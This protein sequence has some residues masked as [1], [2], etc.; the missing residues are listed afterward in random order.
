MSISR[1]SKLT[2][3]GPLAQ[4]AQ[5]MAQVQQMGCL[6][7]IPLVEVD[8]PPSRV[9][10][11][12]YRALHFLAEVEGERRQLT[13]DPDFNAETFVQ[14]VLSLRQALRETA[15]RRDLLAHQVDILRPWGDL[16][17][18]AL[19]DLGGAR[20]W[21]YALPVKHRDALDAVD[22]PWVA[23]RETRTTICLVVI[24]ATEPDAK[25]LPVPRIDMPERSRAEIEQEIEDTEVLLETLRAE[26]IAKTRFLKLFRDRISEL[27][28]RAEFD[29]AMTQTRDDAE[30]FTVQGWVPQDALPDL[31]AYCEAQGVA[32]LIET[33][34]WDETPP[35]LL[36]QPPAEAAGVDLAMF[37]QVPDY[38]AWD[39]TRSLVASFAV[40]FAMIVADAGYGFVILAGL[41]A[42]WKRLGA[43]P[44]LMAW[45]RL[46]VIIAL[47]TIFYGALVGSYFGAEPKG[48]LERFAVLDLN[49]FGTM[50]TLS[51]LI[52]VGHII[53]AIA[54]NAR[55]RWGQRSA[56]GQMGWIAAILGALLVWLAGAPGPTHV[57]GLG[58]LGL[59]FVLIIGFSSNRPIE[60]PTDH[61]LRVLDGLM[62]LGGIMGAFGDVLS[63]M[64]LF[65]LGLAS[66]SL[67]ITFNS[68]AVQMID[69]VPGLGLLLGLLILLIGHVMNFGLAMMSGVVHGL[70]L[71]YIEFYKWGL[72]KEGVAFRPLTR[73]EVQ[74]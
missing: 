29:F 50:M 69:T 7:L 26:R 28:T 44:G 12:A 74:G 49:D 10:E 72:P 2:I 40:F 42:A 46:G 36:Q 15:D 68:L 65:A 64:R 14:E 19:P 56:F 35:T 24:S 6:H 73:K 45:R 1:L 70:R 60:R 25:L 9:A 32:A 41:I 61:L 51:I 17:L 31:L 67:A 11:D 43:A 54:M 71:N 16:D 13:R 58:L 5:V 62:A 18:S 47:A 3:A 34:R 63:Y 38:R 53:F 55:A 4:K 57:M 22:L 39:P 21:F 52:G 37:Y 23:V 33:P 59:G 48:A 8:A 66:A 20:L 30:L 27:E